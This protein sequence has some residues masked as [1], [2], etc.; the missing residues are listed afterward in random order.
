MKYRGW[1][2][3]IDHT[4]NGVEWNR[5]QV[6]D[7]T[8][9]KDRHM[10]LTL[11]EYFPVGTIFHALKSDIDYVIKSQDIQSV[12][13]VFKVCRYDGKEMT[14]DDV[15]ELKRRRFVYRSGYVYGERI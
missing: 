3:P 8:L 13:N 15:F 9:D 7:A 2:Q 10:V 6:L 5:S 14:L 11:Q 1:I 4:I 12:D